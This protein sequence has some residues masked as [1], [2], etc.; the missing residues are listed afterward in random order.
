MIERTRELYKSVYM[1]FTYRYRK[2]NTLNS[3]VVTVT[4]KTLSSL[5]CFFVYTHYY[6]LC[7]SLHSIWLFRV[8]YNYTEYGLTERPKLSCYKINILKNLSYKSGAG[9]N[10]MLINKCLEHTVVAVHTHQSSNTIILNKFYLFSF[11]AVQIISE[12]GVNL[13][14]RNTLSCPPLI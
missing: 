13:S 14:L 10:F 8:L 9:K 12:E 4:K 5:R 6:F 1:L 11:L 3:S 7:L 2:F